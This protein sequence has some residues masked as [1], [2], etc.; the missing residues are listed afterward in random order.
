M[1]RALKAV[2]KYINIFFFSI[3][4]L[5][6][7]AYVY[8]A[9]DIFSFQELPE[10]EPVESVGEEGILLLEDMPAAY[11]PRQQHI[12]TPVKNQGAYGTCWS[13]TTMAALETNAIKK[14]LLSFDEA[15]LSERHLAYYTYYPVGDKLGNISSDKT[16]YKK[17]DMSFL[18]LGGNVSLGWHRLANWQGAVM[19]EEAP[20]EKVEERLPANIESAYGKNS[21]HLKNCYIFNSKDVVWIKRFIKEYGAAGFSLCAVMGMDSTAYYNANNFSYYC[22]YN[23]TTNHAITVVGWDDHYPAEN[24]NHNPGADGAWLVKNS[25]GEEWGDEGYFWLSYQDASLGNN[26]YILEADS[27]DTYDNNYQY[28]GTILDDV[29]CIGSGAAKMA[30]VFQVS[31][32]PSG[33]EELKA[34]SFAVHSPNLEY[35]IQIYKDLT[36]KKNPESGTAMLETPIEG[37]TLS[38][39]FYT[40]ELEQ[41]VRLEPGQEFAVVI[42]LQKEDSEIKVYSE[43]S[44]LYAGVMQSQAYANE[45]ESFYKAGEAWVDYGKAENGNL[46]IKA[47]TTNIEVAVSLPF[48]DVAKQEGNWKYESIKYVY[49]QKLMQGMKAE[50]DKFVF[51]PDAPM[52]RAMFVT[53]L[54]RMAGNP[55]AEQKNSFRDVEEGTWY[56][57]AVTWASKNRITDGV[58]EGCFAPNE[59]ITREQMAKMLKCY[60]DNYGNSIS[61]ENAFSQSEGVGRVGNNLEQYRDRDR[62]SSWARESVEW[63]VK[64]GILQGKKA[65]G[66][67]YL[68]PDADA[69]RAECA[70]LIGRFHKKNM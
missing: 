45:G 15:D 56:Y 17:D 43:G 32:N 10:E 14:G 46:R 37:S 28:D 67:L 68:D 57:D 7:G 69:T 12:L 13:F 40:V 70:A 3:S 50:G 29:I 23:L 44:R 59:K 8:G 26:A 58:G 31:A 20:Y 35:S 63:A 5:L 38:A 4:F 19:E 2:K 53:V 64:C 42:T 18:S 22:P 66:D 11:D 36:D 54:Y 25:L 41:A 9:E 21:I 16:V 27:A 30:N 6:Q 24:F 51:E 65:E 61:K 55:A 47:Y 34:V 52:S 39:G 62:I 1:T 60:S 33:A 49:Q 48:T